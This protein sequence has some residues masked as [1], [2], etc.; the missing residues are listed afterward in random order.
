MTVTANN[1]VE[2]VDGGVVSFIANAAA[3][4]ATAVFVVSAA[5]IAN[6]QAGVTAAPNNADG[7]YTVTASVS[8]SSPAVSFDLTNT[9]AFAQ[10]IVNT[11][12]AALFPGVGLLSLPEAIVFANADSSGNADITFDP[13]VFSTPQ[14]IMLTGTQLELSNTIEPETIAGPAAGVTVSGGGLSRVFQVDGGVTASMS[15]LTISGGTTTGN[16]GGLDNQG[17]TTLTDCTVSGNSA[18][19][20][21]GGLYNLG[22]TTLTGCTLSGNSASGYGGAVFTKGEDLGLINCTVAS[23]SAGMSGGGI[24]CQGT[25]TVTSGTFSLNSARFGGAIDNYNGRYQVTIADSILAG[26]SAQ[27]GP[28]F[29]NAVTSLG[30]NLIGA[31]DGSSGWVGSDLTGTSGTPLN[32]LLAALGYYGG[33]TQTMALLPGSPA[34]DAGSN[35]LIPAGVTT[36]QRGSARIVNGTVDIGAFESQGFTLTPVAG[37]TPQTAAVG[38]PF[39]N[40]LAVTVTANNPVEPVDGGVVSFIANAA[41]NGATAV[42]VVSAVVIANGQ[43]GVT[44]APN[45]ADGSYTVTAS[46]SGSSP[47]VSFDLTNTGAFAQLIVNTTSA[48]LFPGVGLLSLPEAILFANADSSGNADI[49]FDPSVF[50]TPQTIMLTGTQLELSNT[51]EPETIAGPAAGVTVSGGGLSRVFQVDSGVTAFDLGNDDHRRQYRRQ[52]RRP[53]QRWRHDHADQL[54]RQRQLRRREHHRQ[55]RRRRIQL[56]RHDHADQCYPQRQLRRPRRRRP[57][58]QRHGHAD[59]LH[60]QRQLR[61]RQKRRRPVQLNLRHDHADQLHP[62]RQHRLR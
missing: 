11:T 5:V 31:T 27:F 18:G 3:N 37:S 1:P 54:H 32:P 33:P 47:A 22:T 14:T 42:L 48:A 7:S 40:P 45:N 55:R 35:S 15:G 56:G 12:S 20:D 23:N 49:T 59:Q 46:A 36:D 17:T 16:G 50:S 62:Q 13:S 61:H 39:S 38:E 53:L 44:A 57:E 58:H 52:R 25:V 24:E 2:P 9:G 51:I 41:A 6:G 43:A 10:L 29:W 34:I 8:G 60:H 4:G 26:D 30:N 19:N 21:G 28:D